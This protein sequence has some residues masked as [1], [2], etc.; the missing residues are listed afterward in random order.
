MNP[1]TDPETNRELA[2]FV[3]FFSYRSFRREQGIRT[4]A[5][6]LLITVDY[7]LKLR[8][9]TGRT[10]LLI[11]EGHSSPGNESGKVKV[12]NVK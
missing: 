1:E 11:T 3:V 12:T 9:S 2:K 10:N 8:L 6:C 7:M 5:K 4:S